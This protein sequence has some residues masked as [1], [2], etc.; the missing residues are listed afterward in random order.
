MARNL[1]IFT[2][3]KAKDKFSQPT[4]QIAK[5]I[6]R[7]GNVASKTSSKIGGM[8]KSFLGAQLAFSALRKV[9]QGLSFV[10]DEF[11]SFDQAIT[12]AGAKF[13]TAFKRGTDGAKELRKVTRDLGAKTEFSATQA[14]EG[15]DFLAMAGFNAT[16]AMALLPGVVDLATSTQQDLARSTD[17]ASDALGAFGL[18]TKD[19]TQLTENFNRILDVMSKT[20]TTANT[21]MEAMFEAVKKGAPTFTSAGQTVE[22][23]SALVGKMANSGI[24]GSEAGTAL[25]NMMLRLATP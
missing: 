17:I 11:I 13:G 25:R 7:V 9:G 23:F 4:K 8:F 6:K 16:Q 1:T 10:K 15:L 24:K 21:D 20:T 19:D 12:A 2:I 3:F 18:M 14:A 22:T 5:R